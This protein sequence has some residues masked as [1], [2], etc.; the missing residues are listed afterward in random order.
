MPVSLM[1]FIHPLF[2][3]SSSLSVTTVKTGTVQEHTLVFHQVPLYSMS[4][5]DPLKSSDIQAKVFLHLL[6]IMILLGY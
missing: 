1:P 4:Q 5:G 6:Q 2:R 3:E